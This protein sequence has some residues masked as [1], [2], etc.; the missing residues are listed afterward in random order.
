L[1][2]FLFMQMKFLSSL[3][4]TI[5]NNYHYYFKIIF[6]TRSSGYTHYVFKIKENLNNL[7]L[8]L[9]IILDDNHNNNYYCYFNYSSIFFLVFLIYFNNIN[10]FFRIYVTKKE[11]C[12]SEWKNILS[13]YKRL[14]FI[15][16]YKIN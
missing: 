13:F 2:S 1:I 14:I 4:I 5:K 10:S 11:L 9:I 6:W 15:V 12:N 8:I 3:K 16:N 7:T